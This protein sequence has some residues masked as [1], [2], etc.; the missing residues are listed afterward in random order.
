MDHIEDATGM[1]AGL[2]TAIHYVG[3]PNTLR[4]DV[5]RDAAGRR[6]NDATG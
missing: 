3:T 2:I 4:L 5:P 1:P 6:R